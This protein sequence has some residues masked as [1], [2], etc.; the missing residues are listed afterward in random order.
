[1]MMLA[2]DEPA[3]ALARKPKH[4]SIQVYVREWHVNVDLQALVEEGLI[5]SGMS[6]STTTLTNGPRTR[7]AV[8]PAI[9][10]RT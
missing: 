2:E 5:A 4:L 10:P 9:Y 3:A 7:L 8:P 1:M 6:A